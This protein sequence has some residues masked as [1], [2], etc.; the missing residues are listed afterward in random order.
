MILAHIN[1]YQCISMHIVELYLQSR[2]FNRGQLKQKIE[3]A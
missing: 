2:V 1:A 3:N